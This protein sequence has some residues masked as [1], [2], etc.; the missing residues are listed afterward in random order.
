MIV[1]AL[2]VRMVLNDNVSKS[3]K[4]DDDGRISISWGVWLGWVGL[5]WVGL[6]WVGLG[7]SNAMCSEGSNET[8]MKKGLSTQT[9]DVIG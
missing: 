3:S 9:N 2:A 8:R 7:C 6:G 4:K 1:K 5:G